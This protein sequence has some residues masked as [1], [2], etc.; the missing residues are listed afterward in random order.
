MLDQELQLLRGRFVDELATAP[1]GNDKEAKQARDKCQKR[2][3]QVEE[4]L[5]YVNNNVGL[6]AIAALCL[7]TFT[8][9]DGFLSKLDG[10]PHLLGVKG[11]VV[12]ME[13]GHLRDRLPE[14]M[15][16]NVVNTICDLNTD[17]S[18]WNE[19]VHQMMADND[20]H[21]RFLQTLLGYGVTGEVKE[22]I[23]A[24]FIG[25]GWCELKQAIPVLFLHSKGQG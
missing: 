9:E 10:I 8:A 4:R 11:G 22:H 20:K 14:D 18:W 5:T 3:D 19:R 15:V 25:T 21:T 17:C 7:E 6:G 12:D 1:A 24:S 23:F 13:T 16:Y 2:L